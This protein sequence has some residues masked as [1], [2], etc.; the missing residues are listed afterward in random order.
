[1]WATLSRFL[2]KRREYHPKTGRLPTN[3][4]TRNIRLGY[5]NAEWWP[6]S[7]AER[8]P[9]GSARCP[10]DRKLL[11]KKFL[12][13]YYSGNILYHYTTL[14]GFVGIIEKQEIWASHVRYMNDSEEV[15][16]GRF[17]AIEILKRYIIKSRFSLFKKCFRS[18]IACS[19]IRR[20][21]RLLRSFFFD[22]SQ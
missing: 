7:L 14:D 6:V 22:G 10:L 3:S 19:I 12:V 21:S 2:G 15:S 16:H 17:L 8:M 18:R 20:Y 4:N 5:L 13:N 11:D 1:M 9:D